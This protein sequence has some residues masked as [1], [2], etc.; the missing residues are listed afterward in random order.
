MATTNTNT[1]EQT[2]TA[3]AEQT[4]RAISAR[5]TD[6]DGEDTIYRYNAMARIR[7]GLM[8]Y[9]R[10]DADGDGE[11]SK[12]EVDINAAD[13]AEDGE[14]LT[15]QTA[16]IHTLW[17]V[18]Q[19][20]AAYGSATVIYP[21]VQ[22][23]TVWQAD[24]QSQLVADLIDGG[25][26]VAPITLSYLVDSYS[27]ARLMAAR[28][29]TILL[30]ADG[31]QRAES[32]RNEYRLRAD[33]YSAAKAAAAKAKAALDAH[34]A[35]P[36]PT[37]WTPEEKSRQAADA[38][39]PAQQYDTVRDSLIANYAACNAVA[40]A[41]GEKLDKLL[42]A[43]IW[44]SLVP[45]LDIPDSRED[46]VGKL[47]GRLNNG[48]ELTTIE[49]AMPLFDA[50]TQ[51]TAKALGAMLT[52]YTNDAG[53]FGTKQNTPQQVA[54]LL[55]AAATDYRHGSTNGKTATA[56][57]STTTVPTIPAAV[58]QTVEVLT[59]LRKLSADADAAHSK[60]V[61]DNVAAGTIAPVKTWPS[62]LKAK[63][64]TAGH[65]NPYPYW[66]TPAR[67]IPICMYYATAGDNAINPVDMADMLWRATDLYSRRRIYPETAKGA[68]SKKGTTIAD[69]MASRGNSVGA[70][71]TRKAAIDSMVASYL[72]GTTKGK[73][74]SATDLIRQAQAAR[75]AD[76]S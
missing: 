19:L 45:V 4:T 23:D 43:M 65:A 71:L 3:T 49:R 63:D 20:I 66:R 47:F 60:A 52:P 28:P 36:R 35:K 37:E 16:T 40:Q 54:G 21:P 61:A 53:N 76:Q 11:D 46:G 62:A 25:L 69:A 22:R 72:G 70:T 26:Y 30:N 6:A 1:T 32:L 56:Y 29:Q 64:G 17:T 10:A 50:Q 9:L 68:V 12:P 51:Q 14:P 55:L 75:D 31:R 18:Q 38:I 42:N 27:S 48:E 44:V 39:S 33:S 7:A 15:Q 13:A 2:A 57:L 73:A 74:V 24:K 58:T 41:A 67:L 59:A 34:K 5:P 8:D